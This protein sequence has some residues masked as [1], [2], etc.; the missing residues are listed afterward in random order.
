MARRGVIAVVLTFIVAIAAAVLGCT[1]P[2]PAPGELLVMIPTWTLEV[3]GRVVRTVTLPAHIEGDLV[4]RSGA[5][6]KEYTLHTAVAI[7][8]EMRGRDLTLAIPML[9]SRARMIADDHR[10]YALDAPTLDGYR[11]P[12]PQ[13]FRIPGERSDT[14]SLDFEIVVDNS[15]QPSAWIDSVPRLSATL[16]GDRAFNVVRVVNRVSASMG[17]AATVMLAFAYAALFLA[18]RKRF[19]H[20]WQFVQAAA[21]AFYPAFMLGMM[22]SLFGTRDLAVTATML[23]VAVFVNV[24]YTHVQFG[25]GKVNRAWWFALPVTIVVA[26]VAGGPFQVTRA[27]VPLILPQL[28]AA[29]IYN[30]FLF[31][32]AMRA[33]PRTTTLALSTFGWPVAL[34]VANGDMGW[35]LGL[36]EWMGGFHLASAGMTVIAVLQATALML[37]HVR[38]LRRADDLNVELAARVHAAEASN[39]EVR[40]LN[41]ELRR[42]IAARSQQLAESLVRMPDVATTRLTLTPGDIVE[43][44]YRVLGAIGSG[45]M[46]EV[47]L[48][49]R[50]KDS[51]KLAL[52]VHQAGASGTSLARLAR[53]AQLASQID[54]PNA[55][56]IVDVDVSSSG[57]LYIVM[58]YVD[59]PSLADLHEKFGD[60]AWALPLLRQ[61]AE[62]L[63]AIH[64]ASIVHRDLKPGNVLVA[65]GVAKIADFG[66]SARLEGEVDTPGELDATVDASSTPKVPSVASL[67]VT[68]AIMGT[69]L[70]MAPEATRGA[71]KAR[72]ASDMFSFG[73]IA[74]EMLSGRLPFD[75]VAVMA[76]LRGRSTPPPPSLSAVSADVE[77]EVAELVDKCLSEDPARRPTARAVADALASA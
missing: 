77:P 12:G 54:H 4:E 19:A 49:E 36:G 35:F 59:G 65:N 39:V 41:D 76:R 44:R 16:D 62:G 50:V 7:P 75:A 52:K 74:F 45:G 24:R 29:S 21:T 40:S 22:Q 13:R 48:V 47:Y 69:P 11:E 6:A 27:V 42:Q 58:E 64:A 61:I 70:Y 20:G 37:D 28:L 31:V 66:V 33:R 55:V 3:H 30:S 2:A 17:F 8:P 43:D 1:A 5:R 60:V 51:R 18:D 72:P 25:L 63:A 73:V 10:I 56:T 57:V 71:R 26:I 67:T 14:D 46:G 38:S 32:R 15:W 68:G 9:A 34:I 53:E 23:S